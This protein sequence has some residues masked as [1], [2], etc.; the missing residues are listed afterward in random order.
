VDLMM[1][2]RTDGDIRLRDIVAKAILHDSW[3]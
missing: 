2:N 1:E 3:E